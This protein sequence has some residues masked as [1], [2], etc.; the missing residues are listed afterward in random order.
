MAG[1]MSIH[2]THGDV[3]A[4]IELYNVLDPE[5]KFEA[6]CEACE[7]SCRKVLTSVQMRSI[8]VFQAILYGPIRL[9]MYRNRSDL[10]SRLITQKKR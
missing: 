3:P 5:H 7:D 6:V 2:P 9:L 8:R 4:E 1:K 10:M